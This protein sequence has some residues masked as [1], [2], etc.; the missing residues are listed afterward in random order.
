MRSRVVS[1]RRPDTTLDYR[2][3]RLDGRW[4]VYDL[5][6]DGVSLV[7]IYRGEF[8]RALRTASYPRLVERLRQGSL[9]G[10]VVGRNAGIR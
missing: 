10:V 4:K 2:L 3:H 6:L 9:D 5:M 7:A 1:K 8:D